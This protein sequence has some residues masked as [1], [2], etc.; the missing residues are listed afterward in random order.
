MYYTMSLLLTSKKVRAHYTLITASY[1]TTNCVKPRNP[2]LAEI[3]PSFDEKG[4]KGG[5]LF[6]QLRSQLREGFLRWQ[7]SRVLWPTSIIRNSQCGKLDSYLMLLF[8]LVLRL[9]SV[10]AASYQCF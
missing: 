2:L 5:W 8:G 3:K 6:H 10:S 7:S 4:P 1:R 9:L